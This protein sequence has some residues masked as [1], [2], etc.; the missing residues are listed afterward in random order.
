[1]SQNIQPIIPKLSP[2]SQ[3]ELIKY[4]VL[5]NKVPHEDTSDKYTLISS[6]DIINELREKFNWHVTS[7][8]V[9]P[10]KD[11]KRENKQVHLVRLRHFDDLV[12]PKDS[13]VELIFFNS[14]DRSKAFEISLG[15]YRFCCCN[16]LI[17]GETFD[18]YKLRHIGDLENNL[19]EIISKIAE[20][21][22]TLE[23]KIK[24]YSS[25]ILSQSEMETFAK[26][27]IP[28]KFAPHLEVDSKQLLIPQRSEDEENT[29]IFTVMNIIQE[30]LIR[31]KNV[32]GFNKETGR[33]FTSKSILSLKKD[34]EI[35]VGV[36]NLA[37]R[38]YQIKNPESIAA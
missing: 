22:P 36:F 35:N 2:L 12:A 15:L 16:G 25:T 4:P 26:L 10:V 29:S 7:V 6:I 30:N 3:K 8:Q 28:L 1:M 24:E 23:Q 34:Y 14:F 21:K 13:A 31:S 5:Y 18:K 27:S 33:K 19:D 9:S 37:D 32:T 38:I 20:Y 17:L 11:E